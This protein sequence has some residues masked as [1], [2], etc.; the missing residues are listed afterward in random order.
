[1]RLSK[2]STET[3]KHFTTDRGRRIR[4]AKTDR[5]ERQ[6]AGR[7][8]TASR[9]RPMS[10]HC[11]SCLSCCLFARATLGMHTQPCTP[12]MHSVPA[13][14][15]LHSF[16]LPSFYASS[17]GRW[18]PCRGLALTSLSNCPEILIC[19][20]FFLLD[21]LYFCL[22]PSGLPFSPCNV[23]ALSV[24]SSVPLLSHSSVFLF[25]VLFLPLL[26]SSYLSCSVLPVV[27]FY[28]PI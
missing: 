1:M 18:L 12:R 25:S 14:C 7:Q 8:D 24:L 23:T 20:S 22:I 11:L 9:H 3:N 5:R 17:S 27:Q 28:P 13:P 6:T 26:S 21:H 16:F 15:S 2:P 4:S 19:A 10:A